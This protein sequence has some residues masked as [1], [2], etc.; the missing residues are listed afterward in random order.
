LRPAAANLAGQRVDGVNAAVLGRNE[1]GV[2]EPSA[3]PNP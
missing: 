3:P 2:V 1:Y